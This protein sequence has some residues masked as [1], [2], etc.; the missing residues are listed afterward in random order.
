MTISPATT[1]TL[2][3]QTIGSSKSTSI[4]SMMS[5]SFP[6]PPFAQLVTVKLARETHLLWKAQIVPILHGHQL[7]GFVD[8]S[9]PAPPKLIAVSSDADAEKVAN[10]EYSAW[11]AQDQLVLSGLLSTLAPE[12]LDSVVVHTSS[13]SVW[14][15]IERMF[16]TASNA[17][18]MQLR[19]QL[20]TIQKKDLSVSDYF[21]QIK[22]MADILA[23]ASRHDIHADWAR[24]FV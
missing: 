16:A 2:T 14:A 4:G 5:S 8:G 17:R 10:P 12:V 7:L 1:A 11:L 23:A 24:Q 19:C 15:A 13:A 18:V 3:T 9:F 21:G 20:A 6:M 22:S